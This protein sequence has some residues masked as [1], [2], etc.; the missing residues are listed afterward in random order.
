MTWTGTLG[1]RPPHF[2][3][4]LGSGGGRASP[5]EASAK[6]A[7][8][9]AGGT[10]APGT[11][12]HGPVTHGAEPTAQARASDPRVII[13][14]PTWGLRTAVMYVTVPWG[15]GRRWGSARGLC[16]L[17]SGSLVWCGQ[18]HLGMESPGLNWDTGVAGWLSPSG[19]RASPLPVASSRGF[20]AAAQGP[21]STQAGSTRPLHAW[22]RGPPDV[23][24]SPRYS[25]HIT[26]Q[27]K[28]RVGGD[29]RATQPGDPAL[30]TGATVSF[31]LEESRGS[32]R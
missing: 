4:P 24:G 27:Q 25:P 5:E 15:P 2:C 11:Y 20:S 13:C 14:P 17:H 32:E 28:L 31:D 1:L 8:G 29:H 9:L 7:S 30:G 23:A 10:W 21:Q 16:R 18:M 3:F 6:V 26:G 12:E 22:A 19:L